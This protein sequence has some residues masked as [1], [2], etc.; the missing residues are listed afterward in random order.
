MYTN[1]L[2]F[3]GDRDGEKIK[4]KM[5]KEEG[6]KEEQVKKDKA[7]ATGGKIEI[8]NSERELKV[9]PS[10]SRYFSQNRLKRSKEEKECEREEI[11]SPFQPRRAL[12]RSPPRNSGNENEEEKERRRFVQK[13]RGRSESLPNVATPEDGKR[14]RDSKEEETEERKKA[15]QD[16]HTPP[17][18]HALSTGDVDPE[19]KT[20]NPK[21]LK[22]KLLSGLKELGDDLKYVNTILSENQEAYEIIQK[23]EKKIEKMFEEEC[24][25]WCE[26]TNTTTQETQTVGKAQLKEE[27]EVWEVR[28]RIIEG[29]QIEEIAE[30]GKRNW[31]EK[32]FKVTIQKPIQAGVFKNQ[33]ILADMK[34]LNKE[35]EMTNLSKLIP[36]LER[37]ASMQKPDAGGMAIITTKEHS[38]L[39]DNEE[40]ENFKTDR[41][42]FVAGISKEDEELKYFEDILNH[43]K[44]IHVFLKSR[45][46]RKAAIF[47]PSARNHEMIRKIIECCCQD[48][49]V[50]YYLTGPKQN[51]IK[52]KEEPK[53]QK[54]SRSKNNSI[55]IQPA[56]GQTYSEI[57]KQ[58]K[59]IDA[60]DIGVQPKGIEKTKNGNIK[61]NFTGSRSKASSLCSAI[62]Q[63]INSQTKVLEKRKDILITNVDESMTTKDLYEILVKETE[64]PGNIPIYIPVR[65]NYRGYKTATINL[66]NFIADK[67]IKKKFILEGWHRFRILEKIVLKKCFRCQE[68]GHEANGCAN[69]DRNEMCLK[70]GVDGHKAKDCKE[71]QRCYECEHRAGGMKCPNYRKKLE[72]LKQVKTNLIKNTNE[73]ENITYNAIQT[74]KQAIINNTKTKS[75][76]QERNKTHEINETNTHVTYK[77]KDTQIYNMEQETNQKTF[78]KS[79]DEMYVSECTRSKQ[80]INCQNEK[81]DKGLVQEKGKI[82]Q[83]KQTQNLERKN[84]QNESNQRSDE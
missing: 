63:K 52:K 50:E 59:S 79:E 41:I 14:R 45:N 72:K 76:E 68:F 58:I 40:T 37:L 84:S 49:E 22:I 29:M 80:P 4:K 46:E 75:V 35:N 27:M 67:L 34:T 10:I 31:I 6:G 70:C 47:I 18:K 13:N 25:Q 44:K 24:L 56:K 38:V 54:T 48:G 2:S 65:S 71:K 1:K 62:T 51:K 28:R 21:N 61:I 12:N 3:T 43:F 26:G 15:K 74:N 69:L 8:G 36:S 23:M 81:V 16:R 78:E 39:E 5:E 82:K 11:Y 20:P 57:L 42:S 53:W 33:I 30:L 64:Y 19:A 66:P 73:T 7:I 55:L 9:Q 17:R 60:K 83:R 77:I 32:A